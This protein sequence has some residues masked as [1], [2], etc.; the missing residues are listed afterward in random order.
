MLKEGMVYPAR[1]EGYA[2]GG[3]GVAR[4]EGMAVF[5]KGDRKSVV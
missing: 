5:V 2:S 1:I 4:M 3:E